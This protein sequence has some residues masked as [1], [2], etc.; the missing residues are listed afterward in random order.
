MR[1]EDLVQK[2]EWIEKSFEVNLLW[3]HIMTEK[4]F[5]YQVYG[6]VI[7]SQ[8]KIYQLLL[9][10]SETYDVELE[11][12][13]LPEAIRLK[14]KEGDQYGA[15]KDRFWFTNTYGAF[16]I[17]NGAKITIQVYDEIDQ[18]AVIPFLLGYCFS[19]L[20]TQRKMLA[21]H[22]SALAVNNKGI[23]IAGYSGSGKSSLT[24]QFLN[25][26]Y[27]ML[28]DDVSIIDV[29]GNTSIKPGYPT[30]N[31]CLDLI[32]QNH[33]DLKD[34]TLVDVERGKYLVDRSPWFHN[35]ALPLT[36]LF[37]LSPKACDDVMIT[38]IV[39]E[40]KLFHIMNNFFLNHVFKVM[41]IPTI[42]ILCGIELAGKIDV[43]E[44]V[45]PNGVDTTL[46]QMNE[47]LSVLNG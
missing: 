8:M 47:I 19:F 31:L 1:R 42:N 32:Q 37:V 11:L 29:K 21:I 5:Y 7:K 2:D 40:K 46:E 44:L 41:G 24:T 25:N 35:K 16:L 13:L 27:A 28:A 39:G 22:S 9:A 33:Y 43:Y 17:E 38:K 15:M 23:L 45:R 30:Q 34:M 20:F 26:Q 6:I 14:I 36:A 4:L 12:A 18:K 3:R 10:Q